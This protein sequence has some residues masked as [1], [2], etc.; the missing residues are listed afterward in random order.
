M[1]LNVLSSR[2]LLF[3]KDKPNEACFNSLRCRQSY[4]KIVQT[5]YNQACLNC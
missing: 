3:Y 5:E 4:A 2:N 1:Y